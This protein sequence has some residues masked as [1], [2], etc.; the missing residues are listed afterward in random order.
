LRRS[1]G[2]PA[3]HSPLELIAN[4]GNGLTGFGHFPKGRG[5]I[6]LG[7]RDSDHKKEMNAESAKSLHAAFAAKRA[8]HNLKQGQTTR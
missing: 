5:Y 3:G 1:G 8:I 2:G 7:F 6:D 4:V